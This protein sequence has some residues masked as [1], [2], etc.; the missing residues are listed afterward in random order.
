MKKALLMVAFLACAIAMNAQTPAKAPVAPAKK[1]S[2]AVLKDHVCSA[3]CKSGQH[4][5][6]HGEKGHTCGDACKK[7]H[8]S[9]TTEHKCS[10]DCKDGKHAYA[11]GEKGHTCGDACKKMMHDKKKS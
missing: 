3:D 1:A 11:H 10:A 4:A 6:A 9:Q 5:Y 2:V 7:M 8:H